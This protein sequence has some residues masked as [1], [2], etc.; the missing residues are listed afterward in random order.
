MQASNPYESPVTS[1]LHSAATS[2]RMMRVRKIDP[3][4]AGKVL[5]LVYLGLGLLFGVLMAL[6]TILGAAA[7]GGAEAAI[8]GVIGGLFAMVGIPLMYGAMG[9]LGGVLVAFLYNAAAGFVG[10]VEM[11]I[12]N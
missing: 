9:F 2:S 5:G 1:S 11:E 3:I 10:G 7:G 8:G 4:S 6:F 12:D